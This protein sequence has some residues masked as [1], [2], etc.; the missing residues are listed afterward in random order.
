MTP[1]IP[2]VNW[3][4]GPLGTTP[5]PISSAT[6]N[7]VRRAISSPPL[8]LR[9]YRLLQYTQGELP[10]LPSPSAHLTVAPFADSVEASRQPPLELKPSTPWSSPLPPSCTTRCGSPRGA[11]PPPPT[12]TP[13]TEP[14]LRRIS[15][16]SRRARH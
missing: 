4:L 15:V 5:T 1:P 8:L 6:A 16:A 11:R 2:S 14:Q 12:P 7:Q 9:R 10:F 13:C 3:I